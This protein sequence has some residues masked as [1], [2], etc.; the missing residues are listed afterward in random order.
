MSNEYFEKLFLFRVVLIFESGSDRIRMRSF[1]KDA[2]PDQ[3]EDSDPQPWLDMLGFI[4]ASLSIHSSK[5]FY[6]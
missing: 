4:R 5:L 3:I 6:F 2:G 1:F